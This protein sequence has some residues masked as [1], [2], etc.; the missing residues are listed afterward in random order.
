MMNMPYFQ[1]GKSAFAEN[2][3]NYFFVQAEVQAEVQARSLDNESLE[4][5]AAQSAEEQPRLSLTMHIVAIE[6]GFLLDSCLNVF[7][8]I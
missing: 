5:E 2:F 4:D 8:G 7:L 3:A 6:C 1:Q